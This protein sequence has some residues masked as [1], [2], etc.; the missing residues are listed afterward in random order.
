MAYLYSGDGYA[1]S[2]PDMYGTP[3]RAFST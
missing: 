2:P 3:L 1:L